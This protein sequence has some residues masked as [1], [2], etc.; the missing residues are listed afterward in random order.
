MSADGQR[1]VSVP[2]AAEILGVSE[3]TVR[4]Y[5]VAGKLQGRQFG[6]RGR[7]LVWAGDLEPTRATP[8]P[9]PEPR[10]AKPWAPSDKFRAAAR[11]V[12]II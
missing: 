4:N 8:P 6:E 12:G 3:R 1:Y 5:L 9:A 2:R 10:P 11:E 7:W